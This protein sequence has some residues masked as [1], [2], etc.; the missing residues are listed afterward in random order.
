MTTIDI[1]VPTSNEKPKFE[2]ER[3]NDND[4]NTSSELIR[5]REQSQ[6]IP[7]SICEIDCL[8]ETCRL[9]N[10]SSKGAAVVN[11]YLEY[12][13]LINTSW[14]IRCEIIRQINDNIQSVHQN[15]NF[16]NNKLHILCRS[17]IDLY[18]NICNL[19]RLQANPCPFLFSGPSSISSPPRPYISNMSF[20]DI[21]RNDSR[22]FISLLNILNNNK[23][24]QLNQKKISLI[25]APTVDIKRFQGFL[26]G[27]IDG[28]VPE[29]DMN[30]YKTIF[31][32]LNTFLSL[33]DKIYQSW[34]NIDKHADDTSKSYEAFPT[35]RLP[36]K[37]I[38][39]SIEELEW[40]TKIIDQY[41]SLSFTFK[42]ISKLIN[43]SPVTRGNETTL[44]VSEV[45]PSPYLLVSNH[46][47]E[48]TTT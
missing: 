35:L 21:I 20:C 29:E 47:S 37:G 3:I 4:L 1:V 33:E 18:Y 28:V 9:K 22:I 26:L 46:S 45:Q 32:T 19:R 41:K 48:L 40:F 7:L 14:G 31:D 13:N 5:I 38:V 17:N 6:L 39:Q 2:S 12:L 36:Y 42:S 27:K 25:V 11:E 34:L 24:S 16:I 23:F 30:D 43:K 44:K 8:V 15:P 10:C